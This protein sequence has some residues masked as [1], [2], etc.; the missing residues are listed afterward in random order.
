MRRVGALATFGLHQALVAQALQESVEQLSFG[1]TFD[2]ARAELTETVWSK[3][4]S[5]N[6]KPSAYFGKRHGGSTV[7]LVEATTRSDG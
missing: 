4:G 2:Q 6:D 5:I 3:P 1:A 7:A